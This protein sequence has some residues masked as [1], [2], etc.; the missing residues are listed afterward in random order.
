MG[1]DANDKHRGLTSSAVESRRSLYIVDAMTTPNLPFTWPIR[2]YWEDTDAGG[3]VYHG[4]YLRFLER[5]RT[6][7]LRSIGIDQSRLK[8]DHGLVFVVSSISVS[9]RRPARLDDE[10][11]ATSKLS[12]R[13]GASLH[14]QQTLIRPTSGETLL[15]AQVRAACVNAQNFRPMPIPSGLFLD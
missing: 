2:I 5:A 15:E 1:I 7:W 8:T 4:S 3:V 14:F 13:G 11:L 6:E 10:L 12:K 9:F